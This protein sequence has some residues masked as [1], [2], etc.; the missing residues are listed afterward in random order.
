MTRRLLA[1]AF[2][3]V[4]VFPARAIA[5]MTS[6]P[7]LG[8]KREAGASSSTMPVPLREIGF[9]QNIGERLPFDAEVIDERGAVG[10]IGNYFG[11]R[12]VVLVFAYY[13]CPMLCS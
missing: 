11:K 7:S 3:L 4:A 9:D 13:S 5:Q 2:L 6:A 1:A 10:R 12:P 8:Y